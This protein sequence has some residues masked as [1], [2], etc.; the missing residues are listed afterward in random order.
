MIKLR[1]EYDSLKEMDKKYV[2]D[3]GQVLEFIKPFRENIN[4]E[5]VTLRNNQD[6]TYI[7]I[8]H[9]SNPYKIGNL[10]LKVELQGWKNIFY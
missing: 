10:G 5:E 9:S 8:I 2:A 4:S 7:L 6:G 3:P 1:K